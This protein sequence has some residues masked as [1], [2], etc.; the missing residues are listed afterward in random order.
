MV[1]TANATALHSEAGESPL[2]E[3][4]W[5]A[6]NCITQPSRQKFSWEAKRPFVAADARAILQQQA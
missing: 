4:N 1:T 3:A 5:M 6:E 2:F